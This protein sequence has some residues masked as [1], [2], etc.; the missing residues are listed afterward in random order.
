MGGKNSDS[1]SAAMGGP[2]TYEGQDYLQR[3]PDV[4]SSGMQPYYHFTQHGQAEGRTWGAA[5]E[6]PYAGLMEG[7]MMGMGSGGMGSSSADYE[8]AQK[9]AEQKQAEGRIDQ[10]YTDKFA[11]ANSAVDSVNKKIEQQMGY[12]N[13]SGADYSVDEV[14]KQEM[15]N[16]AFAGVWSAEQESELSGM[17]KEWGSSGNK[18]TSG[19][20]RGVTSEDAEAEEGESAGGRVTVFGAPASVSDDDEDKLGGTKQVLGG[21]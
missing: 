1:G 19:I 18:W 9:E 16:D 6:D 3:Y 2:K 13:V 21:V 8:A 14:T 15:I 11:A 10:M 12:A 7:M 20:V 4:A 5:A 17:E